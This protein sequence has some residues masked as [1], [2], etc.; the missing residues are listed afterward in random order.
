MGNMILFYFF[1][2][3]FWI[4]F[5]IPENST[6]VAGSRLALLGVRGV[7][8][9][10]AGGSIWMNLDEPIFGPWELLT[11]EPFAHLG[12]SGFSRKREKR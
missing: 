12:F 10:H 1:L 7:P 2:S 11:I 8:R 3:Y 9:A 6:G 5:F 4:V